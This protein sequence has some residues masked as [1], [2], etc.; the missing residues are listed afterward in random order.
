MAK[1]QQIGLG[2]YKLQDEECIEI[3]NSGLELGYRQI[4]TAQLYHN[5]IQISQGIKLSKIPRE[6]IFIISKISNSN[7]HKLKISESVELIKKELDTNYIDLILLHNPVKNYEKAW[8]ELIRCQTPLNIMN[9]GVSNFKITNLET[10]ITKTN[11]NPWLNQ[12]ELNIFNQQE[13]LIEFNKSKNILTQSHTT[14]TKTNL[15]NNKDLICLGNMLELS[16]SD[17]MF[18]FVLDMGIGILPKTTNLLHLKKNFE[19]IETKKIFDTNFY[20]KNKDLINNF[21]IKYQIYK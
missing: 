19:L 18:K 15:L 4:D 13:K 10:I 17:T 7:I 14:L 6:E 20:L 11:I 21:D 3:I 5:Q 2:T 8:E 16:P 1:Y 12:I 9:I